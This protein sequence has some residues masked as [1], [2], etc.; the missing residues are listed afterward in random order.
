MC[1]SDLGQR[2]I[3]GSD[4]GLGGLGRTGDRIHAGGL[5]RDDGFGDLLKGRISEAGGLVV[6]EDLDLGDLVAVH[7]HLHLDFAA[8][9]TGAY[10]DVLVLAQGLLFLGGRFLHNG[11]GLEA[12][13]DVEQLNGLDGHL[14]AQAGAAGQTAGIAH[15]IAGGLHVRAHGISAQHGIGYRGDGLDLGLIGGEGLY[16]VPLI[17]LIAQSAGILRLAEPSEACAL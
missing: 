3:D 10:A 1:S 7:G 16:L 12:E 17:E 11:S 4:Q 8:D 9:F 6:A 15:G 14:G 13:V 2:V 5:S